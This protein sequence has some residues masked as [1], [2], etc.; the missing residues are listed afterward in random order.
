[1][2]QEADTIGI[3]Q[4]ESRAQMATLPRLRPETFYDIV[5]EVAI[6]RPGPIVGQMVHPY[7]KRRQGE[8]PVVYPH[9]SL[10]PI[11]AR[12]LGVP[13][14]Q[15]QLLRMAMVAA[16][17]SG[18][19]AEELRRAFGFKRSERR[20]Q[21][22][23]GKLRVG[24]AQ[25]GITG[26]AAEEIIRSI[27]SF[28]LYGFPE[29]HA[30]SFALLV[31]ASAYLKAHYPAAFYSA[32]LNNQ[33]MGFYHPST[34]VKD[35]QRHG[36]RFA[37]IDVQVSD[38]TCR[39][40]SDGRVRLGLMYVNGL[41]KEVGEAIERCGEKVR[42]EEREA[43][44][45]RCPKC[46]CDDASMLERL[47]S[48]EGFC[49]VCSHLWPLPFAPRP[50]PLAPRFSSLDDLIRR[51]GIRRDEIATLAEVGA[52]NAFGFDRRTALW[53]VEQAIR[54]VGELFDE[55][56]A[57]GDERTA[58]GGRRQVPPHAPRSSLLASPSSPLAPM[59]THERL[60]ADYSGTSLTIGPHPMSMRRPEL[61][62]RGV[63]RAIDLPQ[64]RHGRR[65]RVAGA[66]ITR[67]RPGTA[68]GFVFLTLEDETGIANIIVR[69]DLFSEQ[70]LV[71]V[72]EP[73]L[74]V[75]G[76]LQVQE[77]VTSVKAERVSGLG[78]GSPPVEAHDFR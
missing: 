19:Q 74:L 29:S 22:I 20:M 8:E 26:E 41:R 40:E 18:G 45:L 71:I 14:F 59:T 65:V 4:V 46:G 38:W 58:D 16:G 7:L 42:G 51:T 48:E 11:L 68:K 67:Q 62:L 2:L 75:E 69:P 17:F 6:I 37:P 35:A 32:I 55:R 77:G 27:T 44:E 61:A 28:A 33:P 12:T 60:V 1:M 34:L 73:Y 70:R 25:Q 57:N 13:L 39:V 63:L 5:V 49:N 47:D 21:Q 54:P 3:F 64:G 76:L 66:V 72:K 36:V 43:D 52:L 78:G 10:E 50:S 31:Y 9:P 23:E 24:M 30:A 15:E 53:Q 56:R